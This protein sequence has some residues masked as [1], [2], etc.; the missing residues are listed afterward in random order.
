MHSVCT[1]T[2]TQI[3]VLYATDTTTYQNGIP[4]ILPCESFNTLSKMTQRFNIPPNVSN[5]FP[6]LTYG[7]MIFII[8]NNILFLKAFPAQ[9]MP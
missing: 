7:I 5:P 8:H 2:G 4:E 3:G 9:G 1:P 6:P